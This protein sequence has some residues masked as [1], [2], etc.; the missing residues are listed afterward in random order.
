M[1]VINKHTIKWG[2]LVIRFLPV[3]LIYGQPI[4]AENVAPVFLKDAINLTQTIDYLLL[5]NALALPHFGDRIDMK[6]EVFLSDLLRRE[7]ISGSRVY[8]RAILGNIIGIAA[9][10][11][12]GA[13]IMPVVWQPITGVRIEPGLGAMGVVLAGMYGGGI[14]GAATG[15]TISLRSGIT[16]WE[17]IKIFSLSL[18]P[19]LI[20]AGIVISQVKDTNILT[21]TNITI[22]AISIPLSAIIPALEYNR[23]IKT[24]K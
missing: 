9:G 20:H 2:C 14:I 21:R 22:V 11:L 18:A 15:T 4:T 7:P 1:N 23:I 13:F 12:L 5:N 19:H 16:N 17:R 3:F 10:S 24:K 8:K 6:G